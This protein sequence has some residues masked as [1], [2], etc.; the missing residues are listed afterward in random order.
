MVIWSPRSATWLSWAVELANGAG[1]QVAMESGTILVAR[2]SSSR[3]AD[4]ATLTN[5]R[6]TSISLNGSV[7]GLNTRCLTLALVL[8]VTTTGE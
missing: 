4:G 8:P 3:I 1:F 7:T 5:A 2:V 6:L